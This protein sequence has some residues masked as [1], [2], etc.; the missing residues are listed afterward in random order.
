MRRYLAIA[1][2]GLMFA[3]ATGCTDFL[4][5]D[6][7]GSDKD[8][9]N[10]REATRDQ[11]FIAA[12]AAQFGMQEA[13]IGMFAC[14][15]MQQC[16]G[17]GGRFVQFR[18]WY[19]FTEVDANSDFIQLYSGGGLLDLRKVQEIAEE[20]GNR[21]YAG[22]AKILEAMLMGLGADVFGDIPYREAAQF[23]TIKQP[24]FDPQAQ[25]YADI[26][27]LLTEAIADIESGAGEVPGA[28]D[29]VYQGDMDAWVEAAWTLKARFYLHTVEQ[30]NNGVNLTA[31]QNAI[32]AANNG[33]SSPANDLR[34]FHG[35]ATSE[36]NIW[37]QFSQTTFGQDIVAGKALV[38]LMVARNDPRLDDYFGLNA[39]G[40][41]GGYDAPTD[42]T[43]PD[44]ISP[45]TGSARNVPNFRQ[46]LVT[47]EENQLILAEA[48]LMTQSAA[49]AQPHLDAVRAQ[50]GLAPVPATLENIIL[51]K[52]VALF[53]N[54][55][56]WN[57]Y[58]RTCFP[59][60]TAV[61]DADFG[62]GFGDE[63]PGRLF[64]GSTEMNAN[65]NTPSVGDQLAEG[66]VAGGRDGVGG[67][68][69][70]NDPNA[71]P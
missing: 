64:Y 18:G 11:L 53:Q 33:I 40:T 45:F 30:A 57:D 7:V 23:E 9:N 15:F 38:D 48:K 5:R 16:G 41:Y 58:K 20:E 8:P 22:V 25:I 42:A 54:I 3:G 68:R 67:F 35:S 70:P 47:W 28:L 39:H 65:P 1:L 63:V 60:L 61:P 59:H 14:L 52:Y 31:Y 34:A 71:C 4:T 2:G 32:A 49:A 21:E 55:E 43:D 17:V 37:Y 26:Q 12:Q 27:A 36:R 13:N 19:F 10:P 46:P 50:Y 29:L 66:G 6:G 69:N 62:H 44:D 56:V 51:E 24:A